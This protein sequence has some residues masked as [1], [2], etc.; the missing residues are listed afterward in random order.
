MSV[1]QW[2]TVL[3]LEKV[4]TNNEEAIFIEFNLQIFLKLG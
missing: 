4:I 2:S 1:I 3:C